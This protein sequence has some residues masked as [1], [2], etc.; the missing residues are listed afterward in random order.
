MKISIK[1][2]SAQVG[3]IT[4]FV[5]CFFF[6]TTKVHNNDEPF[7]SAILFALTLVAVSLIIMFIIKQ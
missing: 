6:A 3:I 1:D 4:L 7:F 2:K 5:I